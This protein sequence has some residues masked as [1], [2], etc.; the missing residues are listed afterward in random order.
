MIDTMKLVSEGFFRYPGSLIDA[1]KNIIT[2][3]INAAVSTKNQPVLL[4]S[5]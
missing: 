4:I 3:I 1:K 5:I 2:V